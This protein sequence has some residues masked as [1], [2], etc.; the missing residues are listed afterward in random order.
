M[1]ETAELGAVEA[2]GVGAGLGAAGLGTS[3]DGSGVAAIEAASVPEVLDARASSSLGGRMGRGTCSADSNRES[4]LAG[5]SLRMLQVSSELTG[6]EI[7]E[8]TEGAATGG[9]TVGV[10]GVGVVGAETVGVVG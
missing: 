4:P 9:E 5:S 2:D 7:G 6:T 10:V 3:G 8:T 1:L